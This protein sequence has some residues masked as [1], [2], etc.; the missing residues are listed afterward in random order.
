MF[1]SLRLFVLSK[2]GSCSCS[3]VFIV[4]FMDLSNDT[5]GIHTEAIKYLSNFNTNWVDTIR[6]H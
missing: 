4:H 1:V 6:Y 5:M 3:M 2:F